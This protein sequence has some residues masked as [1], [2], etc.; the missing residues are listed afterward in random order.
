MDINLSPE[1]TIPDV[2]FWH[3]TETEYVGYLHIETQA[4]FVIQI[5]Y[6]HLDVLESIKERLCSKFSD[7]LPNPGSLSFA[8]REIEHGITP[9]Y[10]PVK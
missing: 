5:E 4:G 9:S 2:R 6:Y 10:F 7:F 1:R 3:R 8:G